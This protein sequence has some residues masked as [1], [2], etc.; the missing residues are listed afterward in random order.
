M[1]DHVEAG[2]ILEQPAGKDLAPGQRL[3][4]CRAFFDEDLHEGPGFGRTLP[5]QAALAGGQ[6]DRD[7]ADPLGLARLE[8]DVLQDVVALV[9]QAQRCHAVLY[10]GAIFVF[11][12]LAGRGLPGHFLRH[13]G[14]FGIGSVTA[15]AGGQREWRGQQKQAKAHQ[16]SGDQA[17]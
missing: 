8:H 3:I 7:I 2:R 14:R 1:L 17:S 6:L 5:R 4:R 10:R 13:F 15:V 16:A 9:E 11:D 12:D